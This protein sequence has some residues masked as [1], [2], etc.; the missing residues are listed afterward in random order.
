VKPKHSPLALELHA[1][2][3]LIDERAGRQASVKLGLRPLGVLAVL[4]EAKS[5]RMLPLVQ[6]LIE[7]LEREI[8]FRI[9][10]QLRREILGRAGE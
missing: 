4:V 5:R 7:R 1:D 9:S 3:V 6:P 2:S 8:D 10:P